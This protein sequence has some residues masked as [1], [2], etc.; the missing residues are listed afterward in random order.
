LRRKSHFGINFGQ[1]THNS[2][3]LRNDS[4]RQD[5]D[6]SLNTLDISIMNHLKEFFM[7]IV[8]R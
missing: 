2:S 8:V 4:E 3:P 1:K 6:T 7:A 5:N